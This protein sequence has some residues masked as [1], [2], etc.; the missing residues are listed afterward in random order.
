M[1]GTLRRRGAPPWSSFVGAGV[2]V[3]L[4]G[5]AGRGRGG[6][7][8]SVRFWQVNIHWG[9]CGKKAGGRWCWLCPR[10]TVY[11]QAPK[12]PDTTTAASRWRPQEC[13]K[14]TPFDLGGRPVPSGARAARTAC[15]CA[16]LDVLDAVQY[17][18]VLLEML[19]KWVQYARLVTRTKE[20]CAVASVWVEKTRARNES[21]GRCRPPEVGR[22]GACTP[23]GTIDHSGRL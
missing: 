13:G 23:A 2:R 22:P 4:G 9:M 18:H 16:R 8:T 7:C 21:E 19:A 3:V 1:P 14:Q 11:A 5:R 20:T 6:G 12:T 10:G 17:H 15:W